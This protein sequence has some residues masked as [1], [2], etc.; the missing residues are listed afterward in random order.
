MHPIRF[1][2][3]ASRFWPCFLLL[4]AAE[5]PSSKAGR[6][7]NAAAHFEQGETSRLRAATLAGA[8][9]EF[10]AAATAFEARPEKETSD[11]EWA[12]CARCAEAEMLL[13]GHKPK[14][15]QAV[16]EL[17]LK[18]PRLADSSYHSLA[19]F[20]HGAACFQRGDDMAAGCSLDRLAPFDDADFGA[21]ARLLL[22]RPRASRRASRG[23]GPI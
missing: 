19:L 8:A 10:D 18:N 5:G 4:L 13:R 11:L 17:L 16:L 20:Y 3:S 21:A 23:V 14:E 12:F 1:I 6:S 9:Q 22:A 2:I 15:A 7:D